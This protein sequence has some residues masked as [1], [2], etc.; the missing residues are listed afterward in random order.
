[1]TR[2]VNDLQDSQR[3]E[4]GPHRSVPLRPGRSVRLFWEKEGSAQLPQ[5]SGHVPIRRLNGTGQ[6]RGHEVSGGSRRRPEA[7]IASSV[8]GGGVC[9]CVCAGELKDRG[10]RGAVCATGRDGT[11][12]ALGRKGG[13]RAR[14]LPRVGD[15]RVRRRAGKRSKL[16]A[17][18]LGA[19]PCV[20]SATPSHHLFSFPFHSRTDENDGE[21]EHKTREESRSG[22][23]P[24]ALY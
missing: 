7:R 8:E 13:R 9:L 10:A 4:K 23:P 3:G 14:A 19:Y 20:Q 11:A 24:R 15:R 2:S 18:G 6:P 1:M 12:A 16:R 21:K 22:R 17:Y 5:L